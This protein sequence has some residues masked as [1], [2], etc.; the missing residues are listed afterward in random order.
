[1]LRQKNGRYSIHLVLQK[2]IEACNLKEYWE[3][4]NVTS[5][6]VADTMKAAPVLRV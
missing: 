2:C 1:M 6:I 5:L 4:Y 3:N